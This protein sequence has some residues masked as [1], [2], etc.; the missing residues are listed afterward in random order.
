MV[1]DFLIKEVKNKKKK[2][3]LGIIALILEETTLVEDRKF[4]QEKG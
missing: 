4:R 1:D 2:E 3:K